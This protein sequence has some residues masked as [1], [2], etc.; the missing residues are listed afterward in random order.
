MVIA[1][2]LWLSPA[3]APN[4]FVMARPGAGRGGRCARSLRPN[5][6]GLIIRIIPGAGGAT[7]GIPTAFTPSNGLGSQPC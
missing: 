1:L 2:K 3:A 6:P 4:S 7:R 5:Q